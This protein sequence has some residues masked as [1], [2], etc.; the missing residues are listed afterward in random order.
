MDMTQGDAHGQPV[1]A[2]PWE[3]VLERIDRL[4]D[5]AGPHS[6]FAEPR[7]AGGQTII[8]AAEVIVAAGVGGGGDAGSAAGGGG[9]GG[10]TQTRPVAVIVVDGDGVR[11]EP[12]VDATKLGLAALTALGS[13][14]FMAMRMFRARKP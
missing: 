1:P 12:V 13:M 4:F 9:G 11:V 5:A 8:P 10:M 6:V 2:A 3:T 7:S 14:A